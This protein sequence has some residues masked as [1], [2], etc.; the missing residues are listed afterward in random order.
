MPASPKAVSFRAGL[1]LILKEVNSMRIEFSSEIYLIIL[2]I[3]IFYP[4]SQNMQHLKNIY[5]G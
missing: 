2:N 3:I 5:E 1:L 4:Y